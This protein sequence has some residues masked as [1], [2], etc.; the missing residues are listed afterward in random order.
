[1]DL[2]IVVDLLLLRLQEAESVVLQ[3]QR[4][5][6][7]DECL[8]LDLE[9]PPPGDPARVH[10]L[11]ELGLVGRLDVGP[12]VHPQYVEGVMR[13]GETTQLSEYLPRLRLLHPLPEPLVGELEKLR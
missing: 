8:S 3:R 9:H 4:P 7:D 6:L 11:Q 10:Q 13:L 12:A 5:P 1:M 2:V